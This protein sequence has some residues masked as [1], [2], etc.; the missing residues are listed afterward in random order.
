VGLVRSWIR[1]VAVGRRNGVRSRVREQLG[2]LTWLDRDVQGAPVT[3]P[4]ADAP[5]PAPVV[6]VVARE[7]MGAPWVR[8]VALD[9]IAAGEVTEV[10]VGT[11][12]I[13]L[14]NVAGELFAVDGVCPHA[15]G[16]L[17][18][19]QLE[20]CTLVCPWHGWSY[21]LRTG[22]SSVDDEVSVATFPVRVVDGIVWVDP[23][24]PGATSEAVPEAVPGN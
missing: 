14:A 8:A 21:D 19:G 23:R 10:V 2:C 24:E 15:G 5:A 3:A 12:S 13:A 9:E 11:R 7:V 4:R 20:D 17:G 6:P 1:W 18:D 16:P 22:R